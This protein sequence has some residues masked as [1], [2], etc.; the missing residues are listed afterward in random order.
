MIHFHDQANVIMSTSPFEDSLF[1][2]IQSLRVV[3]LKNEFD[4]T[5]DIYP[6]TPTHLGTKN[7][8]TVK[9]KISGFMK[10]WHVSIFYNNVVQNTYVVCPT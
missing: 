2:W 10:K 1:N 5:N 6:V 3:L 9:S 4:Q 8:L 7:Q